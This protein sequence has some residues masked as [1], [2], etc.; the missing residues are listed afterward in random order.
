MVLSEKQKEI[1][2]RVGV[3]H[4]KKGMQPVVGRVI[5]LLLVA[6]P[7]EATFD[8]IQEALQ[9]SKSAVSNALTFL[10]GKEI[11][12]Y[13]TKPG[14]RKRYFKLKVKD[15]RQDM[16]KDFDELLKID[17]LIV[18]VIALKKNKKS[19]FCC[20]LSEMRDFL[21]FMRKELPL[22]VQRFEMSRKK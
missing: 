1:I 3:F 2:E 6:E 12:E 19:E 10:Q 11:V 7:A 22:L 4:E 18:D 8:D 20:Y 14:D 9:V 17:A 13:T 5:G 21:G 15:W 16:K